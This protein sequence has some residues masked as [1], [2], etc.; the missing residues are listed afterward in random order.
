MV[1]GTRSR[2]VPDGL[3]GIAK[4]LIPPSKVRPQRGALSTATNPPALPAQ[5]AA[6]FGE[7]FAHAFVTHLNETGSATER[8]ALREA[9][10]AYGQAL[11]HALPPHS[12]RTTADTPARTWAFPQAPSFPPPYAAS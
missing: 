7:A 11:F 3:R 12:S 9:G 5:A 6:R 1:R 2:I 10:H 8:A 4:P